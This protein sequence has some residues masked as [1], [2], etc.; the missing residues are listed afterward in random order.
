MESALQK[1]PFHFALLNHMPNTELPSENH[2][3]VA[4]FRLCRYGGQG[5]ECQRAENGGLDRSWLDFAVLGRPD[6]PPRGPKK[7]KLKGF[8]ISGQQIGHP[9]N[10]KSNRDGSTPHAWPSDKHRRP[11]GR[12][13]DTPILL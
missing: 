6:F 10:A 9:Q 8:G 1:N 2:Q 12:T 11:Q 7:L 5:Y 3:N 4:I 13:S